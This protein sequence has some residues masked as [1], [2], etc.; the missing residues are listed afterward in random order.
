M[1][2]QHRNFMPASFWVIKKNNESRAVKNN[3][4]SPD[5]DLRNFAPC[6]F[7]SQCSLSSDCL[8]EDEHA[9]K[10]ISH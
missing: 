8:S 6:S 10:E 4:C 3:E 1:N 5:F 7:H 9:V 2:T